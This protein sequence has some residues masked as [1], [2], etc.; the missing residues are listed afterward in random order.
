MRNRGFC[1]MQKGC[2]IFLVCGFIYHVEAHPISLFNALSALTLSPHLSTHSWKFAGRLK[3][4][5]FRPLGF[6]SNQSQL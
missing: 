2:A 3:V 6:V 4:P 1:P 5:A